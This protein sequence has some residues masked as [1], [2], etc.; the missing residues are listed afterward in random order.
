MPCQNENTS[1]F[2]NNFQI[3]KFLIFDDSYEPINYE[4]HKKNS[5][6][7]QDIVSS[8]SNYNCIRLII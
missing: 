6:H 2:S 8:K 4:I 3:H 7:K 5:V 1:F